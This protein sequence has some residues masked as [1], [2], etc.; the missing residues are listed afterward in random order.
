MFENPGVK[1]K[2]VSQIMFW[3]VTITSVILAFV[4]GIEK[5]GYGYYER[6][7]FNAAIFFSFFIGGPLV[8]YISTLFL[9]GFGELVENSSEA[10]VRQQKQLEL[11]VR[12][13]KQL[14]LMKA[15]DVNVNSEDTI[16]SKPDKIRLYKCPK[17]HKIS[18][19]IPCSH[20]GYEANLQENS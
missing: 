16:S 14:E 7:E 19:T 2:A 8:A 13:Q 11:L 3:L 9:V 10:L 1:I 4:L 17:C 6:T 18:K 20:C 15:D 12:Q 5:S